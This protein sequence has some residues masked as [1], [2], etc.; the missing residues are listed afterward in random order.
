M[1][2]LSDVVQFFLSRSSMSPKKLQK[3]LYYAYAWT[4][5]LLNES[6]EDIRFRLF[7]NKFQAWVHGPVIPELYQQYKNN[8]WEDIAQVKDFDESIFSSDVLDILNQVWAV[9]GEC[10]GN[11]LECLTHAEEPWQK[12]RAGLDPSQPGS[13]VIDDAVIF[14]YYN[15]MAAE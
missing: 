3:M 13:T 15:S 2:R 10:T 4:L 9:Y 8:G 14:K 7:E 5:A 1:Y 6:A 12:A 11:E